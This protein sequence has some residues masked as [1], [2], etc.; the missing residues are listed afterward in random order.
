MSL[1]LLKIN[2]SVVFSPRKK[3]LNKIYRYSPRLNKPLTILNIDKELP[4]MLIIDYNKF[5][6]WN[7]TNETFISYLPIN[8]IVKNPILFS[9]FI[10]ILFNFQIKFIDS[11][12]DIDDFIHNND[13]DKMLN[14]IQLITNS[15]YDSIINNKL[16]IFYINYDSYKSIFTFIVLNRDESKLIAIQ[17]NTIDLTLKN[18]CNKILNCEY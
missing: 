2:S 8:F 1:N 10:K 17:N 13:S 6:R 5:K 9:S 11:F 16:F 15:S 3:K 4:D 14:Y 7:N 18:E 12:S